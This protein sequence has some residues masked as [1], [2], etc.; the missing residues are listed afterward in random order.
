MPFPIPLSLKG[1][2][3]W[4]VAWSGTHRWVPP[5]Y[6]SAKPRPV[7]ESD[8]VQAYRD[9]LVFADHEEVSCNRVNIWIV[10]HKTK[11]VIT[12]E[13]SCPWVNNREKT[14]EEKNVKYAPLPWELKQQFPTTGEKV[15]R[16]WKEC[17]RR[18]GRARSILP[19][20]LKLWLERKT[21]DCIFQRFFLNLA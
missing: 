21:I 12:L 8:D 10:N 9:V 20:H 15:K 11:R 16:C 18:C 3:K 17:R 5:R 19:G 14:Y 2:F 7:Y 1:T 13:T 6:S 4:D